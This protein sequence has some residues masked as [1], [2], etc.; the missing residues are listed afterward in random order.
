MKALAKLWSELV[1]WRWAP[2]VGL[3]VAS[4]F[5]VLVVVALVPDEIGVPMTNARFSQKRAPA[6]AEAPEAPAGPI[7]VHDSEV[8]P[9]PPPVAVQPAGAV[10]F[11]RRGFSPPL[12]RAEPPPA[13]VVPPP[14]VMPPPVAVA[15]PP[16]PEP[17]L[18]AAPAP[19]PEAPAEA[20]PPPS[21]TPTPGLGGLMR[22][23]Q[24]FRGG[25]PNLPANPAPGAPPGPPP[26]APPGAAPT[27]PGQQQPPDA[28]A[29][30]APGR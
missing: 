29:P 25:V 26:G 21:V 17:A 20:A 28:P 24:A 19:A 2:A 11:G 4:L 23:M 22:S 30:P 27:P 12:E 13:P 5:Y 10:D 9:M 6:P 15:P 1:G 3:S 14:P 7:I 16:V 8:P 18:A